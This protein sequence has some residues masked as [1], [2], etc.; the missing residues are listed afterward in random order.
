M[1][2]SICQNYLANKDSNSDTAIKYC[3]SLFIDRPPLQ[4]VTK[5][6]NSILIGIGLENIKIQNLFRNFM[7]NEL[8]SVRTYHRCIYK[9][10]FVHSVNYTRTQKTN[11]SVIET[12]TGEIIE[13]HHLV[14]SLN[15]CYIC[16][17]I[18]IIGNNEFTGENG[19]SI[20]RHILKLKRKNSRYVFRDINKIKRKV[21]IIDTKEQVFVIFIPNGYEIQ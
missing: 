14:S 9:S 7:K 18:W 17:R 11:D 21:V 10:M 4:N 16:G 20:A 15:E 1:R 2:K 13:N 12:E 6:G 3:K 19:P 8:I 5:I